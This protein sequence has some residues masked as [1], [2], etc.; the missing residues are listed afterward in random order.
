MVNGSGRAGTRHGRDADTAT[1]Q[2]MAPTPNTV[3]QTSHTSRL[4]RTVTV[5]LNERVLV[6]NYPRC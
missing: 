3:Y 6:I 4:A 1:R 5:T 2:T